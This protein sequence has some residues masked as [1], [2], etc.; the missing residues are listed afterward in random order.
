MNGLKALK[1]TD[2]LRRVIE[3]DKTDYAPVVFH[4]SDVDNLENFPDGSAKRLKFGWT[5]ISRPASSSYF[6]P[7]GQRTPID[8]GNRISTKSDDEK[9]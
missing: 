7:Q 2:W 6:S 8:L 5:M 9:Y 1:K 4:E 3:G